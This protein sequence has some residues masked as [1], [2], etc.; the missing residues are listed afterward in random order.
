MVQGVRGPFSGIEKR[1]RNDDGPP[2]KWE[3]GRVENGRLASES[4][5]SIIRP[6]RIELRATTDRDGHPCPRH[7]A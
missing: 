4:G 3:A 7:L 2:P 5:R 1:S 6:L